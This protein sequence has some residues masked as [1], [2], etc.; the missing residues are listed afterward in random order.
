M[1]K[2]KIIS[3]PTHSQEVDIVVTRWPHSLPA[4]GNINIVTQRNG[5]FEIETINFYM[6]KSVHINQTV[7]SIKEFS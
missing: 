6:R 7:A 4:I 1:I 5:A 2:L 3:F